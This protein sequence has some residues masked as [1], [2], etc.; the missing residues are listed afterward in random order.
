MSDSVLAR[1]HTIDTTRLKLQSLAAA[2]QWDV[3]LNAYVPF[4]PYQWSFP[5]MMALRQ[6]ALEESARLHAHRG[7][8]LAERQEDEEA[9][10][11]FATAARRDPANRETAKAM[12]AARV[13]GSMAGA[14][15]AKPASLPPGSPEDLRFKR[16]VHDGERAIQD[17]DFAKADAAIREAQNADKD[18]PEILVLQAKLLAARDRDAEAIPLL[19]AYDREV[20]DAAARELGNTA[21]NDILYDLEKKRTALRSGTPKA[22]T[23]W[24]LFEAPRRGRPGA[25]AGPRG[26]AVSLLRRHRRRAVPRFRHR[27]AAA[28]PLPGGFQ[29]PARG[30][31]TPQSRLA[32]SRAAGRPAAGELDGRHPQLALRPPSAG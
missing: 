28:G 17:K 7:R 26:R 22:A 3:L 1:I 25:R 27:Q 4:E 32:D 8:L 31:G 29:L 13:V 24:R 14:R 19:D 15:T 21:R 6:T 2:G 11:E 5:D 10:Q 12:E 16:S 30:S 9:L 23:G 20:S 18:A